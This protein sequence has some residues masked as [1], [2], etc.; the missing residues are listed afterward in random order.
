MTDARG[1]SQNNYRENFRAKS[2][3]RII[4][5]CVTPVRTAGEPEP[6][7]EKMLTA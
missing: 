3:L 7:D 1:F 4:S 2:P 6:V 5:R